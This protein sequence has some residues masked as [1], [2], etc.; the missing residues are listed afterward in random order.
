MKVLLLLMLFSAM[1]AALPAN[2]AQNVVSF[3]DLTHRLY[4]LK[5]LAEPPIPGEKSGSVTSYDRASVYDAARDLYIDW[6]ANDDFSGNEGQEGD[7]II[8][9][10]LK[11]PGVIWRIWSAQPES[12]HIRLI[13]DGAAQPALDAPF[14]SLFDADHG[15]FPFKNLVRPMARGCNCFV[16]ISFQKSC[17]VMLDK[18]WGRYYQIGYS[19]F[20]SGAQ[21]PSYRGKFDDTERAALENADRMWAERGAPEATGKEEAVRKTIVLKPGKTVDVVAFDKPQAITG[22]ICSVHET[23]ATSME[24]ALREITLSCHWDGEKQ[25]SVWSPLGDFFGSGPG[26]NPYRSLPSG[27]TR[28]GM[29]SSWYMPFNKAVM[30][31]TNDGS[32]S[33]TVSIAVLHEPLDHSADGLLRFHVKWHRDHWGGDGPGRYAK[34]R[35]PDWP[36]LLA[37]GGPGR[38]CGVALHVWNPLHVWDRDYAG[39]YVRKVPE[40]CPIPEWFKKNV[41]SDWWWGEGDEKFFVDG[42]KFPSTFGT[43]SEDYFGYAWGTPQVFDS[44][45]QCQTRNAAN[46]GHLSMA[47]WHI[48][49]DVPFQNSFEASIEKYHGNNWPLLYAATAYWYQAPGVSDSY[50]ALPLSE[51]QG[52]YTMPEIAP[53]ESQAAH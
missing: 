45:T 50:M 7:S 8:A 51:R 34:D 21:V 46:L 40:L 19:Q 13:I 31:L 24:H 41:M 33:R 4:D 6:G 22:V 48:A 3:E 26:L 35:W 49:D 15:P 44:A 25:P 28:E 29:Y 12:G 39:H 36:M 43:G 17:K 47:R 18:G 14:N 11:G 38:F 30:R 2:G 42:E 5:R 32:V 52:Y 9:A 53:S 37:S 10:D 20:P 1:L 27:V 23:E 16:P